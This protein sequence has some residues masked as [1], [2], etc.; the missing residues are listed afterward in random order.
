MAGSLDLIAEWTRPDAPTPSQF[1]ESDGL[2]ERFAERNGSGSSSRDAIANWLA[3]KVAGS[4]GIRPE[5]VDRDLP[6]LSLGLDSLNVMELKLQIDAGLATTL[7]LSMLMDGSSIRELAEWAS[8]QL[9]GSSAQPSET[10]SPPVQ[11]QHG[12]SLSHGQQLLWYAHQFTPKGAA[13]NLAGAAIVRAELDID[14]FRRASC[15]R[16]C[17]PRRITDNLHYRGR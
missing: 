7:P 14:S 4:L 12:Q 8:V 15:S 3:A 13:Y 9:A 10:S 5:E 16:R 6:F 17:R 2:I 1:A 11:D